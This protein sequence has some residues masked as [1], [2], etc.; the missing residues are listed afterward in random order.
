[1]RFESSSRNSWEKI[2]TYTPKVNYLPQ[3]EECLL[4]DGLRKVWKKITKQKNYKEIFI[5]IEGIPDY[6]LPHPDRVFE[7][8]DSSDEEDDDEVLTECEEEV[9]DN[10]SDSEG[11]SDSDWNWFSVMHVAAKKIPLL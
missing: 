11:D 10:E 3:K 4:Q 1:M 6:K 8:D 5:T 2:S 7:M 9:N